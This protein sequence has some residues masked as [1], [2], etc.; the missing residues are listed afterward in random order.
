MNTQIIQNSNSPELTET[1]NKEETVS[2][3]LVWLDMEM[4][5]LD[6]DK[7]KILEIALIITDNALNVVESAPVY[8]INQSDELLE[9]MDPWCKG[10]HGKSGLTQKVKDSSISEEQAEQEI[11]TLLKKY[12]RE[13]ASPLCG[14]T[15][16][17]D[18]RF[19]CRYMP[20]LE[21]FFHYR[22]I[23]VSTLKELVKR[24]K[25]EI[26][27]QFKK[28]NKHEAL[29]DILESIEELKFY[30]QNIMNI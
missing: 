1:K 25:P 11:L 14:N 18:R 7:E 5:G 26:A 15:I 23:D 12:L 13:G 20:K 27:K 16:H 28:H 29:A 19:L 4:S 8:I 24:W 6:P 22:N 3:Y 17:Q 2:P 21:A 10:T 9:N 30:R